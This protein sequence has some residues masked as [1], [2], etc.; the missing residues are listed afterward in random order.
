VTV[1]G[2]NRDG[3][4]SLQ[5][6]DK[7]RRA[8]FHQP[9]GPEHP[10]RH[11]QRRLR[12]PRP[13][14]CLREWPWMV[15]ITACPLL[16]SQPSF[17]QKASPALVEHSALAAPSPHRLHHGAPC[18]F[19]KPG[20]DEHIRQKLAHRSTAPW[21]PADALP[22]PTAMALSC[23]NIP[24][25]A[26]PSDL[27]SVRSPKV[28]AVVHYAPSAQSTTH[29]PDDGGTVWSAATGPAMSTGRDRQPHT[30]AAPS[31]TSKILS[32]PT[33]S[34]H[35]EGECLPCSPVPCHMGHVPRTKIPP[36]RAPFGSASNP[37]RSGK[38]GL[39]FK[40]SIAT[41]RKR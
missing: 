36:R 20:R 6:A 34:T 28:S 35:V 9:Q 17:P 8:P 4:G 10:K 2:G 31:R 16:R 22:T 41:L 24:P 1:V 3:T 38:Q 5:S 25:R 27:P 21:T 18:L 11:R 13:L 33:T 39:A 37:R 40:N 26:A 15:A 14:D 23:Q 30:K 29:D 7:D 19:A 32:H 12:P